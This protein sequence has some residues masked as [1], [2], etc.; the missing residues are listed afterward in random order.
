V[1]DQD[2]LTSKL[3]TIDRCLQRI[4]GTQG[5]EGLLPADVEDITAINLQRAMKAAVDL[6]LHVVASEGL[7]IPYSPADSFTLLGR[8]GMIDR[9]LAARLQRMAIFRDL[10]L[11]DHQSVG[12]DVI[13]AVLDRHLGDLRAFGEG[14]ARS[15][16]GRAGGLSLLK[17]QHGMPAL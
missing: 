15:E 4:A 11:Y 2:V 17:Q 1:T 16:A 7:G 12:P 6:A 10:T 14:V 5:R 13:E 3:A 9:D 8:H